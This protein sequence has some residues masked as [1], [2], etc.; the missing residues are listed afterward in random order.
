MEREQLEAVRETLSE[1]RNKVAGI[2]IDNI[3]SK[4]KGSPA[5]ENIDRLAQ[6]VDG[7]AGVVATLIEDQAVKM[8]HSHAVAEMIKRDGVHPRVIKT[9][10]PDPRD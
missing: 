9:A 5:D 1:I 3:A 4:L 2:G 10:E 7:L 8:E 6:A